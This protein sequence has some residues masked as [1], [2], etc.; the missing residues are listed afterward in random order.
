MLGV[1]FQIAFAVFCLWG[2]PAICRAI[3]DGAAAARAERRKAAESE[4]RKTLPG[5]VGWSKLARALWMSDDDSEK[6]L[7]RIRTLKGPE[8]Q[9]F[10]TAVSAI[11]K[12]GRAL[13]EIWRITNAVEVAASRCRTFLSS[14][15][16][17]NQHGIRKDLEAAIMSL[18][19]FEEQAVSLSD[20]LQWLAT[21][22]L[23]SSILIDQI[24]REPITRRSAFADS[25]DNWEAGLQ[26]ALGAARD[27]ERR[28]APHIQ[29]ARSYLRI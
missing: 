6:L 7:E 15:V 23:A 8:R 4:L 13:E 25:A 29:V 2:L 21:R 24:I 1:L 19:S 3:A 20:E 12:S 17:D 22:C 16:R 27:L 26:R 9:Q 5:I 18:S 11:V 10:D 28:A 14:P